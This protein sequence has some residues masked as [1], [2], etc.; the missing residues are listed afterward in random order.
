MNAP[1]SACKDAGNATFTVFTGSKP[2]GRASFS[3]RVDA[4]ATRRSAKV[5]VSASSAL[6]YVSVW[7]L[8]SKSAGSPSLA[9]ICLLSAGTAMLPS[10]DST[11]MNA[12]CSACK[13]AGNA[14]R[15]RSSF[16]LLITVSTT[17]SR[18]SLV[19]RLSTILPSASVLSCVIV[20]SR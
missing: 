6:P 18:I 11:V 14:T 16:S 10:R 19:V 4:S 9:A 7:P 17:I 12:P 1:C 20:A 8:D 3:T 2:A 5:S 15:T 13:D